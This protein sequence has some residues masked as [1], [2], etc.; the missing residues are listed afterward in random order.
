MKLHVHSYE[1]FGTVDGPGVRFIVFTQGCPMRCQY[2]HNPDT[3]EFGK[4]TAYTCE[5]IVQEVV[6]YR[7]YIKDGGVTISGGEPLAQMEAVI[8]L[9]TQL[10]Q[11]GFHTCV[12]TSGV[13]FQVDNP[14]IQEQYDRLC[15]VCDLFLLD[16]K[17]IDEQQHIQLTGKSN[18]PVF[19]FAQYLQKKHKA[20]W[21]RHVLVPGI[22][23]QA[24]YLYDLKQFLDT[25]DNIE[26]VEV[27]P[28][29]SMGKVKYEALHIP[30]VLEE[31]RPPSLQE[32][33][34]AKR[35]LGLKES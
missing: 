7:S 27:L 28:Y 9:L 23:T 5:E 12:D 33:E 3:W 11:E 24:H 18:E 32:V 21:I 25:L 29:H 16:I 14:L 20:V 8:A 4:G 31:M 19:A 15:A 35:I 22:T 2:C 34:V 10:K 6:K 30:Y 26:K 13:L 17:H 1:S